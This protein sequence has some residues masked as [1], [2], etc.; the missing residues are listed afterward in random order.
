MEKVANYDY[1]STPLFS[2]LLPS[3][4]TPLSY[5]MTDYYYHVLHMVQAYCMHIVRLFL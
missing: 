1:I 4:L 5:S 3:P 2:S